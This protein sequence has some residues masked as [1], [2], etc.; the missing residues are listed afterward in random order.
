VQADDWWPVAGGIAGFGVVGAGRLDE[1]QT[2]DGSGAI[3]LDTVASAG[4][5]APVVTAAGAVDLDSVVVLGSGAA[6]AAIVTGSGAITLGSVTVAG[7][8]AP[9]V[10]ASGNVALGDA[11]VAG[12][13]SPVVTV[14]GAVLLDSVAVAGAGAL[15]VTGAGAVGLDSV[16]V[17]GISLPAVGAT[18]AIVLASVVSSGAG[19]LKSQNDEPPGEVKMS[20]RKVRARIVEIMAG[21]PAGALKTERGVG[22]RFVH[23]PQTGDRDAPGRARGFFLALDES[24]TLGPYTPLGSSNER[25]D[26]LRL[27]VVYP[28]DVEDAVIED[29]MSDDYDVISSR[30]LDDGLWNRPVSTILAVTI[31]GERLLPARY[32]RQRGQRRMTI[33][34]IVEHTR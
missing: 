9:V 6:P 27:E 19:S 13:G 14:A 33:P 29:L 18:G 2:I 20:L 15:V 16:A 30:I 24:A 21:T 7:A 1:L 12:A 25:V 28:D 4:D 5:G 10:T 23:M 17:V 26:R 34:L 31:D 3:T 11:V 32:T 22:P 8:G